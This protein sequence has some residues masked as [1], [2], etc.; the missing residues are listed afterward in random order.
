MSVS[1]LTEGSQLRLVGRHLP[2]RGHHE[3]DHS[4]APKTPNPATP[5]ILPDG[6]NN[7]VE[8][9]GNFKINIK[10]RINKHD[11]DD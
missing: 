3:G 7:Q 6:K 5:T 9:R 10:D 1:K 11:D 8:D 2:P 4:V